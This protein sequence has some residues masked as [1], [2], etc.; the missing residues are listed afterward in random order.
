L[1]WV[2]ASAV[3]RRLMP[4]LLD[5]TVHLRARRSDGAFQRKRDPTGGPEVGH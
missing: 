3:H 1:I 5:Q 4:G 2:P